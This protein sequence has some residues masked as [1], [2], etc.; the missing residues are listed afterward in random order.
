MPLIKFIIDDGTKYEKKYA[1]IN[2]PAGNKLI[3]TPEKEQIKEMLKLFGQN[4]D[5]KYSIIYFLLSSGK[6][7]SANPLTSNELEIFCKKYTDYLES[8]GRHNFGIMDINTNDTVIYDHH[9]ILYVYGNLEDKIEILEKNGYKKVE[10]I[11]IPKAHC[12]LFNSENDEIQNEIIK[13]NEWNITLIKDQDKEFKHEDDDETEELLNNRFLIPRW[14]IKDNVFDIND[15][16]RR[17]DNLN[18]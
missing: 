9:N 13:N 12:H 10:K 1:I 5:N 6:Y 14:M 2:N 4:K 17:L 8:D 15:Y 11:T 16:V 3:V 7:Q 18:L